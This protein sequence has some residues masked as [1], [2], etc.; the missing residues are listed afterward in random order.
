MLPAVLLAATLAAQAGGARAA[1]PAVPPP[2]TAA[3]ATIPAAPAQPLTDWPFRFGDDDYPAVALRNEEQGR[4]TYRVE[5]GPDGRVARCS[6]TGSSG[7]G[8]L[9]QATCR[10]VSR[11]ARFTPARDSAGAPV[12]DTREGEVTWSLGED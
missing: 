1:T 3:P 6:I 12:P 2:A 4:T 9:D 8:W 11:R 7:S 10:I 5:I